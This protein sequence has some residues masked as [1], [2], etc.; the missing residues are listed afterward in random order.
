MVWYNMD[1][2][3]HSVQVAFAALTLVPLH[4]TALGKNQDEWSA[5][6]NLVSNRFSS[7]NN[8]TILV[9]V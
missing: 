3:V 4:G 6:H 2:M 9:Y 8:A 1:T 5:K 7:S